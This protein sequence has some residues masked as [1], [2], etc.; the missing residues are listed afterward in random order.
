[1][2]EEKFHQTVNP[3]ITEVN[4]VNFLLTVEQ[5]ADYL[6]LAKSTLDIWRISGGH[7]LPFVKLGRS[8]RYKKSDL[9]E[10]L[11]RQTVGEV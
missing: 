6:T 3:V 7:G 4:Q 8:V 10:Y 11:K 1:M 2:K 5:A 9:D